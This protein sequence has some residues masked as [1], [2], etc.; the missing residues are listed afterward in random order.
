[1]TKTHTLI[2]RPSYVVHPCI[3]TNDCY[4]KLACQPLAM[5]L[6]EDHPEWGEY[7][8]PKHHVLNF[9][10]KCLLSASSMFQRLTHAA[11]DDLFENQSERRKLLLLH[12]LVITPP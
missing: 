7:L 3:Q 2:G 5:P 1:M 4:E 6:F 9:T 11:L 10:P 8:N 12:E